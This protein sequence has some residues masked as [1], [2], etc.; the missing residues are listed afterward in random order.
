MCIDFCGCQEMLGPAMYF[1][2]RKS[3]RLPFVDVLDLGLGADG[4]L[5]VDDGLRDAGGELVFVGLGAGEQ[6][7]EDEVEAA[8]QAGEKLAAEQSLPSRNF[9]AAV[10]AYST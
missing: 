7:L 1:F 6:A 2:S 8:V 3:K 5:R 9:F 10:A 4:E